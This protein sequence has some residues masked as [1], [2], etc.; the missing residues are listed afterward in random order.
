VVETNV[1]IAAVAEL[2]QIA[3]LLRA[4]RALGIEVMALV[5]RGDEGG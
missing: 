5:E 3:L 2:S 1:G 4:A